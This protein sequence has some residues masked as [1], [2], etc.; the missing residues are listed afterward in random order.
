MPLV[1]YIVE[2]TPRGERGYDIFSRLLKERIVFIH[3]PVTD[4]L[5]TVIQAQLLFLE[6]EDPERDIDIYINSPGGS[7]YAGNAIYDTIQTISCPVA[8]ICTGM[9]ASYGALLLCAGAPGKRYCTPHARVMIHQ[10]SGGFE[11]QATDAEI[12]LREMLTLKNTLAQI[13]A[14]HTGQPLERVLADSERDKWMGAEEAKAYGMID[15]VLDKAL[16]AGELVK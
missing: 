3:E 7:V 13:I 9:A 4:A 8:T 14:S 10:P 2:D 6:K 11:G 16:R 5:A 15:H 12:N 1:P